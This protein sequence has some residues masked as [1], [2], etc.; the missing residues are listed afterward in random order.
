VTDRSSDLDAVRRLLVSDADAVRPTARPAA[1]RHVRRRTI[2]TR[3]P[4]RSRRRI[5]AAAATAAVATVTTLSVGLNNH[6]DGIQL[7]AGVEPAAAAVLEHAAELLRD[8]RPLTGMQARVVRA[9]SLQLV[10]QR[11][12]SGHDHTYVL[13]R[14]REYRFDAQGGSSYKE[15]AD[16]APQFPTPDAKAA[17]DDAFGAYTPVAPKPRAMLT[18]DP[19]E[20][21][22]DT[23]G[24]STHDVVNLPVEASALQARLTEVTTTLPGDESSSLE[25][26]AVRLLVFGPTPPAVRA[27]L[28]ELLAATPDVRKAGVERV[29]GREADVLAFGARDGF[30]RQVFVDR[31]TGAVLEER[32]VLTRVDPDLPG[33]QPGTVINAA[34]YTTAIVSSLDARA[35]LTRTSPQP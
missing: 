27:G 20:P 4:Q 1:W 32:T 10:T 25:D 11:D 17:F 30:A 33:T 14:H 22:P 18:T 26:L 3:K 31:Q 13:P 6:R 34:A 28:A 12:S 2:A 5:A 8:D 24:L 23:L 7:K 19:G 16:G 21:N 9:D 15:F 35:H 29:G